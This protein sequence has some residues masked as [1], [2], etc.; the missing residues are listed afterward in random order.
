MDNKLEIS[1]SSGLGQWQL[2]AFWSSTRHWS[3]PDNAT[4]KSKH[5]TPSKQWIHFLRSERCPPTSIMRKFIWPSSN[6]VSVIPVVRKRACNMSW[7]SGS[8]PGSNIRSSELK[9]LHESQHKGYFRAVIAAELTNSSYREERTHGPWKQPSGL[10]HLST[11]RS[12]HPE[13]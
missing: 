1:S 5:W 10:L 12:L 4:M 2:T 9:K 7:L 13:L 6:S 11:Y 8:Q 3:Y